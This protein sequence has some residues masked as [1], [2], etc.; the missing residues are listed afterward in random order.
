MTP[1]GLPVS[2]RELGKQWTSSNG[3]EPSHG[4]NEWKALRD[5]ASP[6]VRR[7]PSGEV[8]V[9]K[10][11]EW[12]DNIADAHR[13]PKRDRWRHWA[14]GFEDPADRSF[15]SSD[16]IDRDATELMSPVQRLQSFGSDDI[17]TEQRLPAG[18]KGKQAEREARVLDMIDWSR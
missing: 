5:R 9:G 12:H 4:S 11:G 2:R 15:H 8:F 10:R 16:D 17:E 14:R 13:L 18:A 7:R 1:G 3:D 6:A